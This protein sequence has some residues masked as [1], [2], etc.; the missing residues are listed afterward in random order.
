MFLKVEI[1]NKAE[2]RIY[3]EWENARFDNSKVVF[4]DDTRL[5]M[6]NEKANEVVVANSKTHKNITGK[7]HILSNSISKI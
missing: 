2:E 5:S 6:K 4:D 3:I 7:N 1:E